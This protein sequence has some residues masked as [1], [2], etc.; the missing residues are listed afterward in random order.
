MITC[1]ART[2][3]RRI[4]VSGYGDERIPCQA[5]RGLRSMTDRDGITRWYCAAEGHREDVVR[6]F[7]LADPV[8]PDWR[9]PESADPVTMAKG[10]TESERRF[11]W[12]DR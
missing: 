6:R 3:R 1:H 11:A 8:E 2:H 5:T 10:W 9:M 4:S 7:G 12:G